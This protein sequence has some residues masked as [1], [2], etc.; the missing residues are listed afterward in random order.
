MHEAS[1]VSGLLS[2]ALEEV[3]K[4]RA[5]SGPE[6]PRVRRIREITL[7]I[8]LISCVEEQTLTGCFELMAE[9]TLAEGAVVKVHRLPLPCTCKDCGKAFELRE[10]HFVC[11]F[12]G[13][14]NIAFS[15]GQGCVMSKLDVDLEEKTDGSS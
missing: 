10:R 3:E 4:F 7:D 13:S 15:G 6:G 9:G 12:C 1:L 2:L 14:E 8:G 5:S 11:P